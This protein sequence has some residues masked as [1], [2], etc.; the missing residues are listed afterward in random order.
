MK[1]KLKWVGLAGVILVGVNLSLA[2]RF[3]NSNQGE[4]WIVNGD[5]IRTAREAPFHSTEVPNWTNAPGFEKDLFTFARIRY[6]R[7]TRGGRVWWNGGYWYSDYPDSDLNLSY[8]LQQ[9][10]SIKVDPNGRV[11]DLTDPELFSFPWTY[12]VEPGLMILENDEVGVLRNYL[13]NGG[14]LM[15]D[16]FW[17]E[18]QWANFEREMKRVLPDRSFVELP[19]EHPIFHC[20]FDLKGPKSQ[21]QVPNVLIG[22]RAEETGV[23]WE[24]HEALVGGQVVRGG[25]ECKELHIRAI[26]DDKGRIMVLAC[27]N[28]DY[29]DGWERE[30]EDDYFFHRF[31]ENIAYPIGINVIFYSMT[32]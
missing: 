8:R 1:L 15:A 3:R 6:T 28:T 32:H 4:G 24:Y 20:V 26:L 10:T 5:S 21:L 30:G 27:H 9:L 29:G 31:C 23:T 7:L 18:G 2:Q 11:I 14:F 19:L 17:G 13:L 22:R 12:M 25:E 16:D